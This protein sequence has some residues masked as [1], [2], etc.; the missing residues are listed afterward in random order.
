MNRVR[1][2]KEQRIHLKNMGV[3]NFFISENTSRLFDQSRF[4]GEPCPVCNT[5]YCWNHDIS[6]NCAVC[7]SSRHEGYSTCRCYDHRYRSKECDEL[8]FLITDYCNENGCPD[9]KIL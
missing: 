8:Y 5:P 1:E 7:L 6:S 4:E 9:D 2:L 3:E